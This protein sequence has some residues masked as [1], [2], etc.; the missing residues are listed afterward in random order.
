MD[1][2]AR[3]DAFNGPSSGGVLDAAIHALP[4]SKLCVIGQIQNTQPLLRAPHER[5]GLVRVRVADCLTEP[6]IVC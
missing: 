4:L 1:R 2:C 3:D 5:P 6:G